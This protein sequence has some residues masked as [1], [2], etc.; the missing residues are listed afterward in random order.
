MFHPCFCEALARVGSHVGSWGILHARSSNASDRDMR[1]HE[2]KTI[3]GMS[4][5]RDQKHAP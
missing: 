3:A 5:R 2:E 1:F 4:T